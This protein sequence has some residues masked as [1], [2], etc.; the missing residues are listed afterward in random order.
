MKTALSDP[1]LIEALQRSGNETKYSTPQQ[2]RALVD[3][4]GTRFE[5]LLKAKVFQPE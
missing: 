3:K 2:F 4:E 5:A 1:S